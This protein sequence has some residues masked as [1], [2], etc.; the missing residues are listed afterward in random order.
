MWRS[1]TWMSCDPGR[2]GRPR[3]PL[4]EGLKW[5]AA[6]PDLV[7][8]ISISA[9]TISMLRADDNGNRRVLQINSTVNLGNSGGPVVD[10][11]VAAAG[12]IRARVKQMP[13]SLPRFP[14]IR[15]R[16]FSSRAAWI[17]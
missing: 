9:G 15:R 14:S 16:I 5:V 6:A 17:R 7:P 13:N 1:A 8:E 11:E 12:V 4:V 10:R 3:Y 2:R